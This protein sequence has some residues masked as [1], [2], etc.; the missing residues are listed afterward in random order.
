MSYYSVQE[1]LNASNGKTPLW[2]VILR[3]HMADQDCDEEEARSKMYEL[4]QAMQNASENYSGTDRSASGLVGGDAE[5]LEKSKPLVGNYMGQVMA[6]A[7]KMGECNACMK[8]IVAA[9]TAGSCGVLPAV[10]IPLKNMGIASDDEIV[11][12][13]FV[14]AGFG[15]IIAGRA[16]ISGAAGG[17]QAEVGTASAMAAAALCNLQGGSPQMCANA[18]GFA[19]ENL[20][21]LVCDPVAGLVEIPCVRRNVIG[22]VNAVASS[23]MALAGIEDHIPCDQVIDAMREVGESMPASCRET[24]KGG[25]AATPRGA[26]IA[27]QVLGTD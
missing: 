8:R 15:G 23:D 7:L 13:L 19:L 1:L 21:G 12:S 9:P 10:F 3:E 18:C 16:F 20:M 22:A 2:E 14:A 5:K 11:K 6:E 27:S 25:L 24:G 17:C 4:W 26:E